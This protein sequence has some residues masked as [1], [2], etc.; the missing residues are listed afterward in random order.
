MNQIKVYFTSVTS[1]S[2]DENAEIKAHLDIFWEFSPG[3]MISVAK[4]YFLFTILLIHTYL[5][6]ILVG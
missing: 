6:G 5:L 1:K 2:N 3:L 4:K